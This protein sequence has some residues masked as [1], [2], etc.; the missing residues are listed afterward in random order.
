MSFFP[1]LCFRL[2]VLA[3]SASVYPPILASALP[4]ASLS[5]AP[6]PPDSSLPSPPLLALL[7]LSPAAFIPAS[8]YPLPYSPLPFSSP[9]SSAVAPYRVRPSFPSCHLPLP[10]IAPSPAD[11]RRLSPDPASSSPGL[12]PPSSCAL[13]PPC[14]AAVPR[15]LTTQNH[16]LS[17]LRPCPSPSSVYVFISA[18]R[19]RHP[20]PHLPPSFVSRAPLSAHP[21]LSLSGF[22]PSYSPPLGHLPPPLLIPP[23]RP[24]SS[25]RSRSIAAVPSSPSPSSLLSPIPLLSPRQ[26][27]LRSHIPLALSFLP[28]RLFSPSTFFPL[29]S[30]YPPPLLPPSMSRAHLPFVSPG[31]DPSPPFDSLA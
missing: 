14:P 21:S 24:P 17:D 3:P 13:L 20:S 22:P 19:S 4:H 15:P 28:P 26:Y 31:L 2:A 30:R 12:P 6:L 23:S 7:R 10:P 25:P 29:C 8:S 18:S 16:M 5:Y 27:F 11:L 9:T 1:H